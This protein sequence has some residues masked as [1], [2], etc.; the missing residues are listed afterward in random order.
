M[1]RAA[2]LRARC[3]SA[4]VRPLKTASAFALETKLR[5]MEIPST[6]IFHTA[7]QAHSLEPMAVMPSLC[8]TLLYDHNQPFETMNRDGA[9]HGFS[10]G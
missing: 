2:A 9:G 1:R 6:C 10:S 5:Q 3:A 7:L 8:S 4:K